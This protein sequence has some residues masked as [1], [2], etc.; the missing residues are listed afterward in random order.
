MAYTLK[1]SEKTFRNHMNQIH[2]KLAIY[3]RAQAVLDA[4]RKA[5]VEL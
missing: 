2:E 5:P 4:V 3:D 1:N